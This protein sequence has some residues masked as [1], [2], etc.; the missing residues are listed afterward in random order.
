MWYVANHNVF[1]FDL[2]RITISSHSPSFPISRAN[3]ES[4][5]SL[6]HYATPFAPH[7][8]EY[9]THTTPPM[10]TPVES[11]HN[12]FYCTYSFGLIST[13]HRTHK[14][15]NCTHTHTLPNRSQI[16]IR[17]F[18]PNA[19]H[20]FA[21]PPNRRQIKPTTASTRK[22]PTSVFNQSAMI[23][24]SRLRRASTPQ[25][26]NRQKRKTTTNFTKIPTRGRHNLCWAALFLAL[27][28]VLIFVFWLSVFRV[29]FWS[30]ILFTATC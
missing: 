29:V 12:H 3:T 8:R 24:F 14:N 13:T 1:V 15:E 4:S 23:S 22:Q 2:V 7:T 27:S 10:R 9:P 21:L 11:R 17:P 28:L 18:L 5:A 6:T 19:T 30:Y 20:H 16:A 25:G 26:K